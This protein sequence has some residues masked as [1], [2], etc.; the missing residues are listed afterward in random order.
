MVAE[1]GFASSDSMFFKGEFFCGGCDI[2]HFH[3][4][5]SQ[6]HKAV[7]VG[8]MVFKI[9]HKNAALSIHFLLHEEHGK[10]YRY[11]PC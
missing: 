2:R 9:F 3:L 8:C 4:L 5:A 11:W 10:L 6:V 7:Y 1:A